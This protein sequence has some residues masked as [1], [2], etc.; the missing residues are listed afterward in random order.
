MSDSEYSDSQSK[1]NPV[2]LLIIKGVEK[3]K[4]LYDV[5]SY[6]DEGYKYAAIKEFKTLAYKHIAKKI[7][8]R[9][10]MELSGKNYCSHYVKLSVNI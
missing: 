5:E 9:F 4:I 2:D 10:D 3:Q 8:K 1:I 7:L 6:V